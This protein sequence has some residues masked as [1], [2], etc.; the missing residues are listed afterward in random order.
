MVEF[1]GT[2]KQVKW[3]NDIRNMLLK[4]KAEVEKIDIKKYEEKSNDLPI[5]WYE[6]SMQGLEKYLNTNDAKMLINKF[7]KLRAYMIENWKNEN[8]EY[9]KL[10]YIAQLFY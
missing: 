1:Q 4:I 7:S 6:V 8:D 10:G 5:E 3:V 2:E 9:K